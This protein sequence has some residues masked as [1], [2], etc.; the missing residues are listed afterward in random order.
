MNKCLIVSALLLTSAHSFH[1]QWQTPRRQ[2][3]LDNRWRRQRHS[4]G[5][6]NPSTTELHMQQYD[7]SKPVFDLY[8]FRSVRGD[9][10]AKYNSLNQSEP[11]R[12]N[13]F[14]LC[15]LVFLSIPTLSS[16]FNGGPLT[17][18][19]TSLAVLGAIGSAF[20]F[21]Q[22]CQKR[23]KQLTR[24]EK[25]LFARDL[26]LRPPSSLLADRPYGNAMS[27][28]QLQEYG[29]GPRI[30]ALYSASVN[31]M[32]NVLADLRVYGKR[33]KQANVLV[34][35]IVKQAQLPTARTEWLATPENPNEWLSYFESLSS[36][37]D[38]VPAPTFKWFGL[39]STGRS[40]G[41]GTGYPPSWLQLLGQHLR[42]LDIMDAQDD[43]VSESIPED[44][45]AVVAQQRVFYD[46]L[47]NGKLEQLENVFVEGTTQ[48]VTD[49]MNQGGRLDS[50]RFCLEDG[51]RP[52]GMKIGNT[53]VVI[54]D[55]KAR[56][57]S[58]CIEYP[59]ADGLT[60]ARLLAVQEW[61][62]KDG[63]S[64]EWRMV[65]HQTI[66]WSTD[67]TAAGTLICDCRGCVSL[68]RANPKRTFGGLI[69]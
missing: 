6:F 25:E 1:Q 61:V 64:S 34:V 10:L 30:L 59:V 46:A 43:A 11:L 51:A 24:L 42:P 57:F 14:G 31:E 38:V 5:W 26:Q 12:I 69:G 41:S 21:A 37:S 22:E 23:S 20:L 50:W 35:P 55:S 40:F 3:N 27:I 63:A 4:Q 33:L 56:A 45:R 67:V 47:T 54:D 13:L 53:D 49:V 2:R 66:P 36:D 19:Q 29:G 15:I 65:Q 28:Q 8:A 39:S 52:E 7:I 44:T 62:R 16:D 58:T 48:H 9:A 32:E 68:V 60:D 17:I 18:P